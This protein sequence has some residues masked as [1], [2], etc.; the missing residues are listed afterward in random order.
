[1][2]QK[3]DLLKYLDQRKKD[4][5]SELD[6]IHK[7]IWQVSSKMSEKGTNRTHVNK[8]VSK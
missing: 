6:Y 7:L 4:L 8:E 5:G 3:E 1:M 2:T